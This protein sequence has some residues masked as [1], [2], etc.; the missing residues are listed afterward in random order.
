MTKIKIPLY[1]PL[2]KKNEIINVNDCLKSSWIS[3]KGKYIAKF[4][5]L[6]SKYTGIKY[7]TTVVNG[8]AALHLALLALGIK[9]LDEVIVPTYTYVAT[10]NAVSFVGA[11]PIFIDSSIND[12]QINLNEIEKKITKKTKAIICPHIYGQ[13]TDMKKIVYLKKKYN[14]FLIE[15]CAESLG[16]YFNSK[17][18]GQFGDVAT[19][20]FYGSK[21]ITTGEGGMLCSKN[22]K[23]VERATKLKLQ[24]IYSPELSYWHD[25]VGYNYKMTNICA[26]I[27]FSQMA[28]IKSI[29]KDKR[30]LY[31]KYLKGLKNLPIEIQKENKNTIHSFWLVAA[32]TK[33]KKNRDNLMKFMRKHGIETKP[34]FYPIHTMPMYKNITKEKFPVARRLGSSII[35]LPSFP[36]IS[37]KEVNYI[38]KIIKNFFK[39][40]KYV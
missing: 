37:N 21:T 32:I 15:D 20:S 12:W 34:G 18:S 17:H 3:S 19:F 23:I 39:K 28:R 38:C 25:V 6:F 9:R 36:N 13:M 16:S 33:N 1:K 26:A 4:E 40:N 8:T 31:L 2:I 11:K 24:G 14:L 29:L 10:V 30:N 27:G 35:C 22:K 5:E 7:S